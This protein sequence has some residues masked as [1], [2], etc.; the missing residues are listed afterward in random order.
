MGKWSPEQKAK[1]K[2]TMAA[3]RAEASLPPP[4]SPRGLLRVASSR[5][6]IELTLT[7]RKLAAVERLLAL[8]E[9]IL[10]EDNAP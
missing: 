5:K 7:E 3:K 10:G 8:F 4:T 1:F 2:E 6:S 9:K